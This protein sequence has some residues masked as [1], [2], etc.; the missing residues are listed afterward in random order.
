[1][2]YTPSQLQALE[3]ALA[4]GVLTVQYQGRTITYRSTAALKEAISTVRNALAVQDGT[5]VR[6]IRFGSSKGL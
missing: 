1:M 2:A 3:N 4:S 5:R 6:L